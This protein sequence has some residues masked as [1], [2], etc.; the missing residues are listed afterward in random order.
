MGGF[1][2]FFLFFVTFLF[3]HDAPYSLE[4]FRSVLDISKLQAPYSSYNPLYC[5]KYGDFEYYS[6]QYF[7][8]QDSQ[9]MVFYMCGYHNRSE[10]RF[11]HIWKVDT[12]TEKIME[13]QVKLFPLNQKREFTFLQIHADSTLK[14]KPVI[15]KPLL[16]I[17]WYK[18]LHNRYNHLWAVV[19]LS[20][21]VNV[22]SYQKIDLGE[23]PKG[24]FDVKI[25]VLKNRLK[26][27]LNDLKTVD[28]DVRYWDKYYNY[29]KAGVYLQDEGCAKVLFN[30][31]KVKD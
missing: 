30:K 31:L 1:K 2:I 29:F 21:D 4:K 16:R 13:A 15:N 12:A 9:Y 17:V 18:E 28:M 6:N 5:R 25:S 19:R 23:M 20:G 22:Q 10:L 7:Y 14:D 3:A 26:I 24:F 8:L 11:K 27:Y